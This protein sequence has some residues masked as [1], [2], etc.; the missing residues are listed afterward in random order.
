MGGVAVRVLVVVAVCVAVP[1]RVTVAVPVAVGVP[2]LVAVEVP[3]CVAVAVFVAVPVWVA[4]PV[5]VPVRVAVAVFVAVAVAVAVRVD[6]PVDVAVEVLVD[7]PVAV[8]VDVAVAV[9]VA[10]PVPVA[11]EVRVD[12]PVAVAVGVAVAVLVAVPVP[13]AVEVLV[14]VPV[15]VAVGV[16]VAVLVAVPV[17]VAVEVLVDVTV[18]VAVDVTVA[19]GPT[20]AH[21]PSQNPNP[22]ALWTH[23][24]AAGFPGKQLLLSAT[25]PEQSGASSQHALMVPQPGCPTHWP[26]IKR[27]QTAAQLAQLPV[28]CTAVH[29]SLL[30]PWHMQHTPC[31][32][33]T[34]ATAAS[35][36]TAATWSATRNNRRA[37]EYERRERF[38]PVPRLMRRLPRHALPSV[39]FRWSPAG[40]LPESD[41]PDNQSF[42]ARAGRAGAAG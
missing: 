6:V 24:F 33:G 2:V 42:C 8:A 5:A 12:V 40:R 38:R 15:A 7:V 1:V 32:T 17:P 39:C 19:V 29:V 28:S 27:A 10:V 23:K 22:I 9:L 18:A 20:P 36:V 4:V 30:L 41:R 11:V 14:D 35:V 16:A 13:V 31:A 3:L 25:P 37:P 34:K 21:V 26:P